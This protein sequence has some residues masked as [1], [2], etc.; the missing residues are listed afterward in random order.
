MMTIIG[1]IPLLPTLI[2]LALLALLQPTIQQQQ[3]TLSPALPPT[4][5]VDQYY[6]CVFRAGGLSNP[7]FSF[8]RL[9]PPLIGS[10]NGIVEGVPSASG[11]YRT[12]VTFW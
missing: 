3:Y 7:R 11:A 5:F 6:S 9:P 8:S 12:T 10:K 1:N 4:A 2:L